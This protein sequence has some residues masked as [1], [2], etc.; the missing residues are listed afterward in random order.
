M[1][2]LVKPRSDLNTPFPKNPLDRRSDGFDPLIPYQMI[3]LSATRE[4]IA[5]TG[6]FK[7]EMTFTK[8]DSCNM[9]NFRILQ[10][11]RPST[12]PLPGAGVFVRRI[13]LPEQ[14]VVQFTL[15]GRGLGNT[16]LEGRDRPLPAP[17]LEP[18]FSLHI[19]VKS[20]QTRRVAVCY[21]FDRINS[22]SGERGKFD[23]HL[24]EVSKTYEDQANIAIDNIDGKS[25]GSLEAR[26]IT[27][28]GSM[29]TVFNLLDRKLIGRVTKALDSKFP[30]LFGKVDAVVLSIPVPLKLKGDREA[31]FGGGFRDK[32][33]GRVFKLL[34]IGPH[35][36]FP[37]KSGHG[38]KG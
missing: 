15:D 23:E 35:V 4:M 1:P 37:T 20:N 21:V 17:L 33:T 30:D 7:A 9:S 29:G 12:F 36:E 13:T 38:V 2:V 28:N 32:S 27:L 14:S 24:A 34:F 10:Q 3:P 31:G 22:D 18:D 8:P 19:S 6:D 25:A 26:T 5:V 16:V 11:Q